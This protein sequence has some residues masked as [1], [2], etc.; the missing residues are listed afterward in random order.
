MSATGRIEFGADGVKVSGP[1]KDGGY[2]VT[3]S[4][5]EYMQNQIAELL[6]IPQQTALKVVVEIDG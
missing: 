6:R 1:N 4:T 2:T 3:F 5:G